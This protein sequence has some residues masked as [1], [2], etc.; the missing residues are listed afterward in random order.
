MEPSLTARAYFDLIEHG[1]RRARDI[2]LARK[3]VNH[4]FLD[5]W[6]QR[7]CQLCAKQY[8]AEPLPP[9][10]LNDRRPR[11][12]P[13]CTIGLER[14]AA[15]ASERVGSPA[16]RGL[17]ALLARRFTAHQPLQY[18]RPWQ[19][20]VPARNRHLIGETP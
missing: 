16:T 3:M 11:L 15:V 4:T 9:G 13:D 7:R 10:Q 20:L 1:L 19:D 5:I 8:T 6:L 18:G 14:A 12:C 17:A 2:E